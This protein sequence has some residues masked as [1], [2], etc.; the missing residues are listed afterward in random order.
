MV[1][2]R[3][4]VTMYTS[5]TITKYIANIIPISDTTT[6]VETST[7]TNQF[8]VVNTGSRIITAT[9]V[10]WVTIT[11]NA[12]NKARWALQEQTAINLS[13]CDTTVAPS[14]TSL[15]R[16][17][18]QPVK[19]LSVHPGAAPH[20]R[21]LG[22]VRRQS[23][24]QPL[25]Q[26]LRTDTIT[27]TSTTT[28]MLTTTTYMYDIGSAGRL[29]NETTI[30]TTAIT[31]TYTQ[32]AQTTIYITSTF[33]RIPGQTKLVVLA[34]SS[35]ELSVSSSTSATQSHTQTSIGG[36]RVG[37]GLDMGAKA[38]IGRERLWEVSFF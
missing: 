37:G 24:S 30:L 31:Q 14:A 13:L 38:G 8:A 10:T 16:P 2:G 1:Y 18:A 27:V 21:H 25:S 7:K 36:R 12:G 32:P 28:V 35:T 23:Q 3:F 6:R 5:E 4:Y 17:H 33:L 19:T 15:P 11:L 9:S 22:P 26:I 29:V 34:P 20:F